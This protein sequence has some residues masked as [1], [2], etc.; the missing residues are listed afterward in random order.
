MDS[1]LS[2][3]AQRV[4]IIL[5]CSFLTAAAATMFAFAMLDPRSMAQGFLPSWWTTRLTVYAVGFFFF[6]AIAAGAS[7][8][9]LYML[10]TR[11]RQGE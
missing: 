11:S 4:G 5:W 8:L 2:P 3:R 7:T 9:T 6:W 1:D 10:A